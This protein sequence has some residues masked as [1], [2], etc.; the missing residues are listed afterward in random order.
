MPIA[1]HILG[2]NG[3]TR[4]I[5]ICFGINSL[6]KNNKRRTWNALNS[7]AGVDV[8]A[9]LEGQAID[10]VDNLIILQHDNHNT[11]GRF[12]MWLTE[13]VVPCVFS[14]MVDSWNV[15]NHVLWVGQFSLELLI[16]L[17]PL[18]DPGHLTIPTK[19][20]CIPLRSLSCEWSWRGSRQNHDGH[21]QIQV[22]R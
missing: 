7:F 21:R 17:D 8:H 13:E 16:Y 12:Y 3:I 22:P 20:P 1:A 11:F 18:S 2:V 5:Y 10:T 14:L 9:Q 4:F 19:N 15:Q 6:K